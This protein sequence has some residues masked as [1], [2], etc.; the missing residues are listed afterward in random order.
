MSVE[1][2]PVPQ[3]LEERQTAAM[4]SQAKGLQASAAALQAQ[5]AAAAAVAGFSGNPVK[6]RYTEMVKVCV[7][8]RVATDVEGFL[9][10]AQELCDGIDRN[11][12]EPVKA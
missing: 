5:A 11:Y 10:F 3:S 6:D 2:L 7:Q 9:K 4:E 8:A 12:P 1:N